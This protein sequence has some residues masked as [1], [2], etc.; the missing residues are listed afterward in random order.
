MLTVPVNCMFII[1]PV[2]A[3]LILKQAL[4]ESAQQ[5]STESKIL[6]SP[7]AKQ[8]I[9]DSSKNQQNSPESETLV[10][11]QAKQALQ[12]SSKNQQNSPD[13]KAFA[14]PQ[15]KRQCNIATPE[16][17]KAYN[18]S[19]PKSCSKSLFAEVTKDLE[20]LDIQQEKAVMKVLNIPHPFMEVSYL[21]YP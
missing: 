6:V 11:S 17:F 10:S 3:C 18:T 16:S 4:Q 12:D 8:A 15:A 2:F 9:Q 1:D 13:S 5:N 19:T 7:Q 21:M 20:V 14:S